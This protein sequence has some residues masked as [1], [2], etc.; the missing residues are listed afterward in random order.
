M[1]HKTDICKSNISSKKYI[2]YPFY[3]FDKQSYIIKMYV[4]TTKIFSSLNFYILKF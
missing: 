3:H 1:K 4:T 2:L